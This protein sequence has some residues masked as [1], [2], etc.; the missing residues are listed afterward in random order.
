MKKNKI[1]VESVVRQG[2][3]DQNI[4]SHLSMCLRNMEGKRVRITLEEAKRRR[5][6]NQN[7]YY[8]GVVIPIILAMFKDAGNDVDE[9]EVHEYLKEHIG[10]L[11]HVMTTPDGIRK[12]VVTSST[13]LTTQEF[14]DY[15]EKVRAWAAE[16]D[17]IIPLPNE[18]IEYE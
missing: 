11:K 6:N 14:E 16:F 7:A 1:T 9:T 8:W 15:M 2:K 10:G 4:S 17:L 18:G 12:S 3:L 5:S 13:K